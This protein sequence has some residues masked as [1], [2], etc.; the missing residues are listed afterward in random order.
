MNKAIRDIVEERLLAIGLQKTVIPLNAPVTTPHLH[1]FTSSNLPVARRIIVV[2]Y[3]PKDDIGVFAH[4]MIG[5]EGG[6]NVGSAVNL[7]RYIQGQH[8][9]PNDFSPPAIIL[10]N[11]GQLRWWRKGQKAVTQMTWFALPQASAVDKPYRFD[12]IKNTIEGN[13]NTDEHI[14]Y[15]FNHVISELGHPEA[16]VDVI[17]VSEGAMGVSRFLEQPANWEKWESRVQAFAAIATWYQST[18]CKN[19]KFLAWMLARSRAYT[20]SDEP[21]GTFLMGPEGNKRSF[22]HGS[23]NR[24]DVFV[25]GDH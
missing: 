15:I 6:I 17:G 3:E 13:R 8:T 7:C 18:D 10:A 11:M 14:D 25:G 5:G 24:S 21:A 22:G 2:F 9:S 20:L 16:K 23:P 4:R 1:I 12:K 19:P